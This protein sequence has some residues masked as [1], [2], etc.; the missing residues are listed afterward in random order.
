MICGD[1]QRQEY[2]NDF[3]TEYFEY[4]KLYQEI[5]KVSQKFLDWD[6]QMKN[7]NK[8]SPAY[9]V[10]INLSYVIF[11]LFLECLSLI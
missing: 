4:Q 9:E 8:G 2:K 3:N 10:S 11:L 6:N 1:S 5:N 7:L